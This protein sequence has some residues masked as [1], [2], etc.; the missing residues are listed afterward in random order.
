M[1]KIQ[2]WP[3]VENNVAFK[4]LLKYVVTFALGPFVS[5]M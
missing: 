5:R 3:T 1:S 4:K 2:K